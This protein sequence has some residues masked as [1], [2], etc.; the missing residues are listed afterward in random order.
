MIDNDWLTGLMKFRKQAG[1]ETHLGD[2]V[3]DVLDEIV[4]VRKEVQAGNEVEMIG[5]FTDIV[6]Y[7]ENALAQLGESRGELFFTVRNINVRDVL[8]DI[9]MDI[10]RYDR[11]KSPHIFRHISRKIMLLIDAL[12]YDFD[13]CMMETTKKILSRRGKLNPKTLKWEKDRTQDHWEL[14]HPNYSRC[15]K[16]SI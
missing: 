2:I 16:E 4:E 5:E 1:L 7:C 14:Y 6:V 9:S 12:G 11:D 10:V 3:T 13:K 8:I 15:K